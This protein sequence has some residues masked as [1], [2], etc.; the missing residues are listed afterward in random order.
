MTGLANVLMLFMYKY[1]LQQVSVDVIELD[2]R[3][4]RKPP[5][6]RI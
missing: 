4:G 3:D 1:L 5:D 2:Q 6:M